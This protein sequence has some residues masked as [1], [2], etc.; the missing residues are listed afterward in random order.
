VSNERGKGERGKME[1]EAI[2][3]LIYR[4]IGCMIT[5]HRELGPGFLESV[6]HR[7]LELELAHQ[8][9]GF[10]SEKEIEL[11][12]RG[13]SIGIHRLD[14]VV[15]NQLVVELK[16]AE[17]LHKKHYAQVRSYLKATRKPVG[18]LANFADYQLDPRRV[19]LTS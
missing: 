19:E 13:K 7:A 11:Q 12:Y 18:L 16:T 1:R 4:V 10:E 6:Y 9:I 8:G 3:D 15:E 17:T 2:D 14:L 5:V